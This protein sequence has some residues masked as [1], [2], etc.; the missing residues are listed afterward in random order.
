MACGGVCVDELSDPEHCGRC[1]HNCQAGEC[2]LGECQP[3]VMWEGMSGYATGVDVTDTE[4]VWSATGGVRAL[5]KFAA[6]GT[7]PRIVS[8]LS[9]ARVLATPT[10]VYISGPSVTKVDIVTGVKQATF[11]PPLSCK[12]D[13][14]VD[15]S[16]LYCSGIGVYRFNLDTTGMVELQ[17]GLVSGWHSV[18]ADSFHVYW[19]DSSNRLKRRPLDLSQPAADYQLT[20]VLGAVRIH[21]RTL[22]ALAG[23]LW[24]VDLDT[25]VATMMDPTLT[26][27]GMLVADDKDVFVTQW[28]GQ[29]IR[30]SLAD[31][32]RVVYTQTSDADVIAM[33][34]QYVFFTTYAER[35]L[36]RLVR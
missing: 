4:V 10:S 28:D 18:L 19:V 15:A 9:G 1:D 35:T 16:H 29:V 21:N 13:L 14:Q 5:S 23:G 25:N 33:D 36:Y 8:T 24:S 20:G 30:F 34:D 6:P 7:V 32:K 12:H 22:Y 27:G 11:T 3:V 17:T 2:L 31:G 26:A